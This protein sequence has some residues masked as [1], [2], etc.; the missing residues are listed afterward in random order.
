MLDN[1][2][3]LVIQLGPLMSILLSFC[4]SPL[5]ILFLCFHDDKDVIREIPGNGEE[6]AQRQVH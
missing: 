5:C 6:E 4:L 2:C 3:H 1:G